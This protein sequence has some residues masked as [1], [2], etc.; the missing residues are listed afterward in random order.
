MVK[1]WTFFLPFEVK[2]PGGCKSGISCPVTD[3]EKYS[4]HGSVDMKELS[5]QANAI[6][7]W[8]LKD[9]VYDNIVCVQ[10]LCKIK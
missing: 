8:Y 7:E 10:I 1:F 5:P 9:D 4:Y 2:Q 6:V 3:G